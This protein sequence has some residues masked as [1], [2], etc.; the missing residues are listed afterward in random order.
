MNECSTVTSVSRAK[1]SQAKKR[2]PA[3]PT[4]RQSEMVVWRCD[5]VTG[6]WVGKTDER[7]SQIGGTDTAETVKKPDS[8]AL[9]RMEQNLLRVFSGEY[10][11][12][13]LVFGVSK[14]ICEI[15]AIE[16]TEFPPLRSERYER[17]ERSANSIQKSDF[18]GRRGLSSNKTKRRN[19]FDDVASG[20]S[21]SNSMQQG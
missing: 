20:V 13:V 4:C 2:K 9:K 16:S 11:M 1:R 7:S 12:R 14:S 10:A 5:G 21:G 19:M 17:T 15:P 8:S 18:F 3:P 6:Q